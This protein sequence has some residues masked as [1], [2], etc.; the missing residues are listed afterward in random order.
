MKIKSLLF[1][2]LLFASACGMAQNGYVKLDA[3][4]LGAKTQ[5]QRLALNPVAGMVV[6]Q[7]DGVRGL[8]TYS[9]PTGWIYSGKSEPGTAGQFVLQKVAGGAVGYATIFEALANAVR[10]DVVFCNADVV[11]NQNGIAPVGQREVVL[12]DGVNIDA[13]GHNFSQYKQF[14]V[15]STEST[16]NL[17]AEV[18]HIGTISNYFDAKNNAS[19]YAEASVISIVQSTKSE[20][21]KIKIECRNVFSVHGALVNVDYVEKSDVEFSADH[22]YLNGGGVKGDASV[23]CYS[24][25]TS[26][27]TYDKYSVTCNGVNPIFVQTTNLNGSV[28]GFVLL[29]PNETRVFYTKPSTS[30]GFFDFTEQHSVITTGFVSSLVQANVML[31][32]ES[33]ETVIKSTVTITAKSLFSKAEKF[34]QS[35]VF[36]RV[37]QHIQN[38]ELVDG[39]LLSNGSGR[40]YIDDCILS[41]NRSCVIKDLSRQ[42]CPSLGRI[43]FSGHN[44]FKCLAT[45]TIEPSLSAITI[46]TKNTRLVNLGNLS[47]N[48]L[49]ADVNVGTVEQSDTKISM[50]AD[51]VGVASNPYN[52]GVWI[53]N[54]AMV[55]PLPLVDVGSVGVLNY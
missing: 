43:F 28:T 26:G 51:Y 44:V 23:S 12:K 8:Y 46:S 17:S 6:Y 21:S 37:F 9:P 52:L 1:G 49:S 53:V 36:C 47:I 55:L 31:P 50:P 33:D 18:K 35:S 38:V 3:L 27:G 15:F 45:S 32:T 2:L 13:R 19:S 5:V 20:N 25:Y 39:I 29:N 11:L 14:P 42:W 54:K 34:I 24:T 22:I 48:Q 30:L 16:P 40:T 4:V 10:G 7:S 41:T